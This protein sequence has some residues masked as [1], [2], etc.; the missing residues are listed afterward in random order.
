MQGQHIDFQADANVGNH[1]FIVVVGYAVFCKRFV[2]VQHGDRLHM[3]ECG[4]KGAVRVQVRRVKFLNNGAKY[5][6]GGILV[7]VQKNLVVT[8]LG[9]VQVEVDLDFLGH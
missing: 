8:V 9:I 4:V 2:R 7:R 3:D 5:I 6:I 1:V